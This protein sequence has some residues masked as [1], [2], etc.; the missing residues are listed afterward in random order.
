MPER[1]EQHASVVTRIAPSPTGDPHV[2]TAYVGLFNYVFTQQQGGTF[3]LR[4]EDTD[5]TRYNA[6]S[7]ARIMRMMQWLGLT[8]D[9]SPEVGGPNGPYR[10]SERADIYRRYAQEL[11]DQGMLYRAFETPEE[12]AEIREQMKKRGLSPGYDGR[13]RKLSPEESERRAQA[14]E[15][16][17]LRLKTPEEGETSFYD[18]LRGQ[19]RVPH[20]EL[21]DAVMIKSDGFPTYH[22]AVV[23]DDHLM[24]VT[25]VVRAE[26][27]IV[28]TPLHVILYQA[29]GWELPKFVHMPLLRNPDK[30]KIS[31]RKVD[32]SVD[33]Y[34]EQGILP[35]A[36]LNYLGSMG[37]SMPDGREF[38]NLEEM[39]E[40]FSFERI[41]LGGPVFDLKRLRHY[42][43]KYMRDLLPLEDLAERVRPFLEQAGLSWDDEDYLLDVIDVLT[44]RAETLLDFVEQGR[45]FFVEDFS[46]DEQ[47]KKKLEGGQKYLQ[48]LELVF[49]RLDSDD[50]DSIDD[51]VQ[52]Y[53][54]AQSV[55]KGKV[56]PPL[57]A[58][59]TGT[60]S[61]PDIIEVTSIL[62]RQRILDRIGRALAYITAGLPDD[63]PQRESEEAAAGTGTAS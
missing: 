54:K 60:T 43:A 42:N 6:E 44:P 61:S 63:K 13:A 52:E 62:G 21:Q 7:E 14:G 27:W 32:T 9:E 50:P 56:L 11:L 47:A 59:L 57:R 33:S 26:D 41:S 37:W 38:F 58:A 25:H 28:S 18:A 12:L 8:P 31:K 34:R 29:F 20:H 3:I 35:E 40:Q 51:L 48:D 22:F 23:V 46:F 15:P 5:R 39:T 55:G 19:I 45:Y 1:A 53:V 49:A 4:V 17:V 16:Y 30:S 2:G 10:Q 36:L 24:G